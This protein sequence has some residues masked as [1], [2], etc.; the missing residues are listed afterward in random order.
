[1][2]VYSRTGHALLSLFRAV[3]SSH[4]LLPTSKITNA[5][6]KQEASARG[7][8]ELRTQVELEMPPPVAGGRR[9]RFFWFVLHAPVCVLCLS[10]IGASASASG[11]WPQKPKG[12]LSSE[13]LK[14]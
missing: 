12:P 1:M 3:A 8:A 2:Q 7:E 6:Q 10:P 14:R 5:E 9:F 4:E 13:V 11:L